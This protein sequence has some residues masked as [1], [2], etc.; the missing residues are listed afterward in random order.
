M[1]TRRDLSLIVLTWP[2]QDVIRWLEGRDVGAMVDGEPFNWEVFAFTIATRARKERDLT[3]AHIALHIYEELAGRIAARPTNTFWL[4]AMA[5]RVWMIRE[6]GAQQG[7]LVLDPDIVLRWVQKAIRLSLDEAE[8]LL[9]MDLRDL[10]LDQLLAFRDIK[11][12]LSVLS[13]I[14]ETPRIR[15]DSSLQA[16]LKLRDRLP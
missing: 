12:A 13:S 15:D 5:L 6:L 11:N 2:V 4:S 14:T 7:N 10:S 16:W 9:S 1:G 8:R 3:W